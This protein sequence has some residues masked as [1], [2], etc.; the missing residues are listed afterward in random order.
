M[1]HQ[2]LSPSY[3][4]EGASPCHAIWGRQWAGK[5][6]RAR[7]DNMGAVHI[8]HSHQSKD[9]YAIHLIRCLSLLECSLQFTLVSTHI[10]GK[11]NT[12][13][14]ALSRNNLPYFLSN[15]PQARLLPTPVPAPIHKAL[16]AQQPDWTSPAWADLFANIT[17]KA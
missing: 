2:H 14:D 5:T 6:I 13:A 1:G 15:H 9:A 17:S 4:T 12:L 10:P 3:H 7:C 8:I 16:I 11:H